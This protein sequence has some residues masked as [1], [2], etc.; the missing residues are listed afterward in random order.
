MTPD[1]ALGPVVG[2][3]PLGGPFF[4]P[5][6]MAAP[7]TSFSQVGLLEAPWSSTSTPGKVTSVWDKIVSKAPLPVCTMARPL[8]ALRATPAV[9][10]YSPVPALAAS[11]SP[12]NLC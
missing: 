5:G 6:W 9:S 7:T 2:M 8:S 1:T 10:I 11:F 3:S 12:S 4:Q